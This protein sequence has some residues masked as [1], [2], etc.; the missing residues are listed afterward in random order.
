M[1][2]FNSE[3]L[4][5]SMLKTANKPKLRLLSLFDL[6]DD[7]VKSDALKKS[8]HAQPSNQTVVQDIIFN[9]SLTRFCVKLS[10]ESQA[11]NP[12]VL[13]DHILFIAQNAFNQQMYQPEANHLMHAQKV[14]NALMLA[15]SIGN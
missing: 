3:T 2:V 9:P 11:K 8:K 4:I 6:L 7:I 15:Q 12:E 14:A 5:D 1:P 13:A 10:Q